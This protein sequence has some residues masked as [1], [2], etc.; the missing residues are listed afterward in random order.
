MRNRLKKHHVIDN[1]HYF[2]LEGASGK[3]YKLTV[4]KVPDTLEG[5][6]WFGNNKENENGYYK[7]INEDIKTDKSSNYSFS[8]QKHYFNGANKE[9]LP[10]RIGINSND[11]EEFMKCVSKFIFPVI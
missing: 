11:A 9:Y 2:E 6:G 4:I 1:F 8:F 7:V 5:Y 3:R 10:N